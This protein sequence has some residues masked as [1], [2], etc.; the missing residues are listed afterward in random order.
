MEDIIEQSIYK[1]VKS[2]EIV[3]SVKDA[4]HVVTNKRYF[5]STLT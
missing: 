5:G 1:E 3:D 2:D 4:V